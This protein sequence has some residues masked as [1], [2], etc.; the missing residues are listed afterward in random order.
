MFIDV[1]KY[2]WLHMYI[3]IYTY[4]YPFLIETIRRIMPVER[5]DMYQLGFQNITV[6]MN[7][8]GSRDE[9]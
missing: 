8:D 7:T 5:V 3:C 4:I 2:I 6:L 9:L 1:C